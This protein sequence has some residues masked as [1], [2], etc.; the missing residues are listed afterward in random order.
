MVNVLSILDLASFGGKVVYIFQTTLKTSVHRK[1]FFLNKNRISEKKN[2][3]ILLKISGGII[4][5]LGGISLDNFKN[6][7]IKDKLILCNK[8]YS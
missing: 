7:N 3:A 1:S 4:V 8:V 2:Y 6:S 5:N